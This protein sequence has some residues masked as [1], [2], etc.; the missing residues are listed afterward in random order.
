VRGKGMPNPR[1][2]G[3]FGDM[4]IEIHMTVPTKL[5]EKQ[6]KALADFAGTKPSKKSGWF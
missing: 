4:Y 5:T 3:S 1:R 2:A 6:K